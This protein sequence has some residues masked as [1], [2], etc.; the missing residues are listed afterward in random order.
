MKAILLA[1][2]ILSIAASA[3]T[4]VS[5]RTEVRGNVEVNSSFSH[6]VQIMALLPPA[7]GTQ[8]YNNG[9]FQTYV[10]G[11]PYVDG[12]T[13]DI[14][15]ALVETV[16]ATS[17]PQ[18]SPAGTDICQ[19]DLVG[20]YHK[21]DWSS[22]ESTTQPPGIWPWFAQFGGAYK[23]VNLI[24]SG[25]NGG[26]GSNTATPWYVTSSTY[27]ANFPN[28]YNRQD[29]MN[30]AKD[31]TSG[32]PWKGITG[33]TFTRTSP[34]YDVYVSL[35][36][37]CKQ[38]ATT[39]HDQ[40]SVW[41]TGAAD[42][43]L[44]VTSS[45]GVVATRDSDNKFHYTSSNNTTS[46]CLSG[47][48]YI[49]T[50]TSSPIP[51][52]QPYLVAWE[53]FLAAANL[54]FN[55][56]YEAD[57]GSGLVPVGKQLGYIRSGTWVGGESFVF[58]INGTNGGSSVGLINLLSPYTY[59]CDEA[60]GGNC[61]STTGRSQTN[62]NN[63]WLGDYIAKINYNQSLSPTMYRYWPIDY[64]ASDYSY[65]NG[66]AADAVSAG[67]GM[68][69]INGFG[70]QAL[71]A[72]D[73]QMGATCIANWC[74]LFGTYSS[75]GS[76]LE[77]QPI[78]LSDPSNQTCAGNTCGTPPK[79]SGD[80]RVWLPFAVNNHATVFEIYYADLGLAFDPKYCTHMQVGPPAYCDAGYYPQFLSQIQE[81]QWFS[82][83]NSGSLSQGVGQG[84][85]CSAY[86]TI[87]NG[88]CSYA[89]YIIA[90]HGP[91]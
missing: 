81:W 46:S 23:K 70:S 21:Y 18:C 2:H 89:T 91:H 78:S 34:S 52:E 42:N 1:V 4:I 7:I 3:Q 45:S 32:V 28:P 73:A 15:W 11:S 86:S 90:A 54:H 75:Y 74:S 10:M 14:E 49:S 36:G 56:S 16:A 39:L 51:Y 79:F 64:I 24:L 13:V 82:A 9:T 60:M 38:D 84:S 63:T 8:D 76:P 88:D 25:I 48:I 83:G 62:A 71:S 72:A 41:I 66:M 43:S 55:P 61:S 35:T 20:Q 6:N 17:T 30:A 37:C 65:P 67:N 44:N 5:R 69:H 50:G 33:A 68:G 87:G 26:A 27:V 85:T 31:C 40:D 58:C 19:R 12:V 53:A 22:Y 77:L 59:V 57:S 80:L 47:C 29:V